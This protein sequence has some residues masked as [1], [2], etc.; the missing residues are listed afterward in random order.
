[1][2]D[3]VAFAAEPARHLDPVGCAAFLIAS[4]VLAGSVQTAWFAAPLSRRCAWP[5][6]GGLT[7]R[8]QRVFGA[9]KTVRGLVVI[10]PATAAA[11]ALVAWL[12]RPLMPG[13][14]PLPISSYAALGAW[15][16]LGF[17]AGELPNSFI[18]RQL[19]VPPGTGA[20]TSGAAIAQ[21][22]A[23]RLDS[24]LGMLLALSLVVPMPWLTWAC[25]LLT[26]PLV[27][28]G[29]SVLMFHLGIKSRPA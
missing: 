9:N 27:H 11:F 23:D 2:T 5:L 19:R 10:I 15:A 20:S 12:T 22:M 13:I 25:V 17:M 16:A 8:G 21:F 1:M 24:G 6:D 28:W 26:G 7:F 3:P 4:F 29:F 18:K 14:W